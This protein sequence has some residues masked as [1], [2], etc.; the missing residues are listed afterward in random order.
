VVLEIIILKAGLLGPN[1]KRETGYERGPSSLHYYT[2]ATHL[3]SGRSF[4]FFF[5]QKPGKIPL[6]DLTGMA[7]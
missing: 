7:R 1:R 4:F 6:G 2:H 3:D 5:Q